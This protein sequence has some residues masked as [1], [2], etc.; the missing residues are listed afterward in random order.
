MA[1]KNFDKVQVGEMLHYI[2]PFSQKI[3]SIRVVSVGTVKGNN[4]MRVFKAIVNLQD[5]SEAV[6]EKAVIQAHKDEGTEVTKTIILPG[7]IHYATIP[8][9]GKLPTFISTDKTLLEAFI[10]GKITL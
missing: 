2:S 5:K 9:K 7:D 10:E 8:T 1:V 3:R 6:T 4:N